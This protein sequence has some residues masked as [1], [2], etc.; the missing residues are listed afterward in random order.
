M[1]SPVRTAAERSEPT[2]FIV[3][4]VI[5]PG[6]ERRYEGW[7]REI[8]R[9]VSGFPGYLG[10]DVVLPTH[11]DRKYTIIVRFDTNEH[12]RA[13]AESETRKEFIRR[14]S[15]LIEGGDQYEIRTGIDFWFEPKG[16]RPPKPWKQFLLTTTA[17][18]PLSLIIPKLLAPLFRIAPPLGNKLIAGLL[19]AAILTALLTYVVMPNYTRLARKWLYEEAE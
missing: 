16:V 6:A 2:A 18:Y 13:W 4:H 7:T 15:D 1:N 14:A 10:R 12:L 19:V 11:G 3:T 9:A 8:F 5:K 17:V